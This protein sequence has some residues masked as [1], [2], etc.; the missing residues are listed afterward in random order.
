[1]N[2]RKRVVT[3]LCCAAS[4][5]DSVPVARTVLGFLMG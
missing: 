1:M 5:G 3:D 4:C 2:P